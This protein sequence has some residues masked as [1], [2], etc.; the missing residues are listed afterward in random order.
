MWKLGDVK[1]FL[2]GTQNPLFNRDTL[3]K[4]YDA[5]V[6]EPGFHIPYIFIHKLITN[7]ARKLSEHILERRLMGQSWGMRKMEKLLRL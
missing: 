5:L 2:P 1:Y 3:D 4:W 7:D 6:Y